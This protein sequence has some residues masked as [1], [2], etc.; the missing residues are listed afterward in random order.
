LIVGLS[1]GGPADKAG[2]LIGDII[3]SAAG[4]RVG[5]IDDV[6]AALQ[7][8]TV[9]ATIALELIRGSALTPVDVVVGEPPQ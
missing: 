3:V 5:D 8:V 9:G 2:L 7:S 1:S 6:Q 4:T